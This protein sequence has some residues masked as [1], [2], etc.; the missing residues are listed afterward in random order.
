MV[1]RGD[2]ALVKAYA[3][4]DTTAWIFRGG[5]NST[6]GD[7]VTGGLNRWVLKD[8]PYCISAAESGDVCGGMEVDAVGVN[9][10]Y[11]GGEWVLNVVRGSKF[12]VGG[13]CH[14][15][16]TLV[17]PCSCKMGPAG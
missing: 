13:I 1:F 9:E 2:I 7:P 16:A 12:D 10:M 8:D 15:S 4:K 3:N 17:A 6:V 5:I 11:Q 14:T